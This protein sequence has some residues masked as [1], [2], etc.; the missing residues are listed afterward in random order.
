MN[1]RHSFLEN[2]VIAFAAVLAGIV[3]FYGV[4]WWLVN[5]R[6]GARVQAAMSA[7]LVQPE[8]ATLAVARPRPPK[9]VSKSF[10]GVNSLPPM[11]LSKTGHPI[12]RTKA[13]PPPRTKKQR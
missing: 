5:R 1:S 13:P 10:V 4:Q 8:L 11:A 2:V 6:E 7:G 9:G 12:T 3:A